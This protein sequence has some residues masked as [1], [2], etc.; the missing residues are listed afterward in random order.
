MPN[1]KKFIF[2]RKGIDFYNRHSKYAPVVFFFGGFAWDSLTLT[3]IDYLLDNLILLTYLILLGLLIILI[4][5][6][7]AGKI[8]NSKLIKYKEFYPMGIQF[9]FGGLFSSY[10][11]FYF[12]SASLTK[13]LLFFSIL[14]LL[15]I[16]N[17]FLEKRLT[18]YYLQSSLYFL[19][20]FSFSI[21]FIPVILKA[22]STF[23]FV[24]GGI[25]SLITTLGLLFF[26]HNK[27]ENIIK[28]KLY[29]AMALVAGI[30]V[31]INVFYIFNWIPPVPL[32]LKE[33]IV[34]YHIER[35]DQAFELQFQK[36]A[37]YKFWKSSDNFY[38]ADGDTAF[39]FTAIF[40]PTS[41]EK[42]IFHVWQAYFPDR[43]EWIVTDSL[44]FQII[45]GRKRGYRGYTYKTRITPGKWRINVITEE[46][47]ILGR[48]NFD[49][50]DARQHKKR[51]KTTVYR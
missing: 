43:R 13:T 21:F 34:C 47:L 27:S 36:S 29:R 25:F 12:Q 9:F 23:T 15:L 32:S 19:T 46:D 48:I 18:N 49:V 17:E 40:A 28:A 26:I 2:V 14:V 10:V 39:C 35:Q 5:L 8:L 16:A 24:L 33:G 44:S 1:F 41:L 20:S 38:Y 6:I 11:V 51:I 37:W 42:K 22:M 7:E 50:K 30:Y 4:N 3:R 31:L 45:G